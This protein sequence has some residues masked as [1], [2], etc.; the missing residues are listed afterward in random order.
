MISHNDSDHSGGLEGLASQVKV[1]RL[2]AGEPV[3]TSSMLSTPCVAGQVWHSGDLTVEVLWPSKPHNS[4]RQKGESGNHHS[5]VVLLTL[6]LP[7]KAIKILL[8]GDIGRQVESSLF[9]QWPQDVD[10][11]VA[12]HHGSKTSS[13]T[14]FIKR[15]NPVQVVFSAGHLS[16][17]NHP[18]QT[19]VKRF[20]RIG[21]TRWSTAADGAITWQW[22]VDGQ[23]KVQARR[24]SH[25]RQWFE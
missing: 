4:E 11:L 9:D 12:A 25:K 16:R 6:S 2:I 22:G 10:V 24:H 1:K 8:P 21:A 14:A 7:N 15:V 3:K 17:Y 23:L 20:E 13:S 18:N 19:V 5:C